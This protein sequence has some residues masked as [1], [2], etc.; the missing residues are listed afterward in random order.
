MQKFHLYANPNLNTSKIIGVQLMPL[1]LPQHRC[2][3]A[4]RSQLP[5]AGALIVCA[6]D[7]T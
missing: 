4:S 7:M 6:E 2:K 5:V 1:P 3:I